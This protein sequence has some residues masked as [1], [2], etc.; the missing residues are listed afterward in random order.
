[1]DRQTL[2]Q[3]RQ[4]LQA[5]RQRLLSELD[6]DQ[7]NDAATPGMATSDHAQWEGPGASNHLADDATELF[8][9][10]EEMTIDNSLKSIVDEIDRA[11]ARIDDGTYGKCES[12]G[13]EIPPRRLER[14]PFSTLC[15]DCKAK[16]EQAIQ[17]HRA[18]ST[19]RRTI[20]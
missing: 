19:A 10:E 1:M 8:L 7:S 6:E 5:E 20:G 17:Q 15:V 12:C 3:F 13:K 11:L 14:R 18:T 2:E 4:R 16:E 9:Q